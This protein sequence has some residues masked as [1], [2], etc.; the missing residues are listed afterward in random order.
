MENDVCL[1]AA[2]DVI[3]PINT[4]LRL[5]LVDGHCHTFG[6]A[7]THAGTPDPYS[8]EGRVAIIGH[9]SSWR[10]VELIAHLPAPLR[11]VYGPW[12][13]GTSPVYHSRAVVKIV[14]VR[15]GELTKIDSDEEGLH[16]YELSPWR[17]EPVID[18]YGLGQHSGARQS[19]SHRSLRLAGMG[20][21]GK[22]AAGMESESC[23][24]VLKGIPSPVAGDQRIKGQPVNRATACV[25]LLLDFGCV[26]QE[27]GFWKRYAQA[28]GSDLSSASASE[29]GMDRFYPDTITWFQGPSY[30]WYDRSKFLWSIESLADAAMLTPGRVWPLAPYDPRRH[31]LANTPDADGTLRDGMHFV[32]HAVDDLGFVGVKLYSRT[33]FAPLDN[34]RIYHGDV[35]KQVENAMRDLFDYLIEHDLPVLNH[36]SPGGFPP[37]ALEPDKP[38]TDIALGDAAPNPQGHIVFPN[39]FFPAEPTDDNPVGRGHAPETPRKTFDD[40]LRRRRAG[41]D[42]DTLERNDPIVASQNDAKM[43]FDIARECCE[44][45]WN[46]N[47]YIQDVVSPYA[48]EKVLTCDG[49]RYAKLRLCFAHV[50]TDKGL[51]ETH[52]EW[53][54]EKYDGKLKAIPYLAAGNPACAPGERFADSIGPGPV[55]QMSRFGQQCM[56]VAMGQAYKRWTVYGSEFGRAALRETDRIASSPFASYAAAKGVILALHPLI[57]LFLEDCV[58]AILESKPWRAALDQWK[59]DYPKS[60]PEKIIELCGKFENVYTDL[61]YLTGEHEEDFEALMKLLKH[62]AQPDE[63]DPSTRTTWFDKMIIGTDWYMIEIDKMAPKDFWERVNAVVTPGSALHEAWASK[64][65]IRWLNLGGAGSDGDSRLRKMERRYRFAPDHGDVDPP[66]WWRDLKKFYETADSAAAPALA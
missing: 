11:I 31:V 41:R 38:V 28:A 8:V 37:P 62:L 64:N 53:F 7:A 18:K 42:Q 59:A 29:V 12:N 33:G 2:E 24:V 56:L 25:P 49:G 61:S 54:A 26:P 50:G 3:C 45:T 44:W 16:V 27:Y 66:F 32:K 58:N 48:W 30:L 21:F 60:W 43:L 63:N 20:R 47:V 40:L 1:S 34:S 36:T 52:H 22:Y 46:Y 14:N 55:Y 65:V 13:L 4:K 39:G 15:G 23:D 6:Q 35:A 19:F 5:P 51:Y 10:S 17:A 9:R 57:R